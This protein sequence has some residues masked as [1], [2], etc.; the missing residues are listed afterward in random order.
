MGAVPEKFGKYQ[1]DAVLGRGGMG[2]VYKAHDPALDR[3]VALK[4]MRGPFLDDTNARERFIRE[5][6]AA[7]GLRHPNIV[8]VYDLGEVEGQMFIAMEFIRGEDLEKIIR[9]KTPL[10]IEDK[11]N[12]MIQVCEGI[13]Y[14]HKHEIVHRDLKPSNIRI[15]EEGIAKIMDFGIAKLGA[16]TMTAT[17]TV[18]GTPFYM[19]P[20][21]VRGMRVDARSDIFSLGAILYEFFTY[22]KAFS[23]EMS[24]VFYKIV[25]EQAALLS[26][27]MDIP[28][29]PLQKI[30]DRCLEKDKA[31]RLQSAS[32]LAE[33]L[34]ET[35]QLYRQTNVATICGIKTSSMSEATIDFE[36]AQAPAAVTTRKPITSRAVQVPDAQSAATDLMSNPPGLAGP[37]PAKLT[38]KTQ[39]TAASVAAAPASPA[40]QATPRSLSAVFFV[41]VVLFLIGGIGAG[42]YFYMS[43]SKPGGDAEQ[44]DR[45]ATPQDTI[46]NEVPPV[47]APDYSVQ[48]AQAKQLY[49]AG[50]YEDAIG[51]YDTLIRNNPA[52][53]N[54]HFLKGAAKQK[55]HKNQE[56]LM[57]YQ[58][59]VELNPNLNQAWQQIG[60]LFMNRMDYKGAEDAFRRAVQIQPDSAA[61]WEGLAQTYLVSQESEKAESAYT[62]LLEIEPGNVPA[63]YNLGQLQWGRK[64]VAAAK[65]SFQRV[66]AINPNYA[67]AHNNLGSIYLSEGQIAQSIRENEKAVELKPGLASAHYSL[68]LAL[69]QKK[70][71][72]LAGEHLKTYLDLTEDD[73]PELKKKLQKYSSL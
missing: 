16:S 53:G 58:R 72:R 18:M 57:E 66:L 13:S 38:G 35:Q 70:N 32:E 36:L 14:A 67:E 8:T 20:E 45:A 30:I 62:K 63:I 21:Q 25:H 29:E 43:Y 10:S 56:A 42:V 23:G 41:L 47:L 9:M 17:G 22:E 59:A 6:Q 15:D 12:I 4:I 3:F 37:E 44:I 27:F 61:G 71:Y 19:S 52:D 31:K 64:D 60:S 46:K 68:F 26:N 65:D 5:A 54:L 28:T 51:V 49:Q 39:P 11:L 7:G 2:E 50:K 73:D 24:A 69:E 55:I 48:L 34:R 1:I 33:A 40:A